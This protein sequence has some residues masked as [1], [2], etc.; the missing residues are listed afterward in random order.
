[1]SDS[2]LQKFGEWY[3]AAQASE[4]ND[5]NAMTVA[6]VGEDGRPAARILLLKGFDEDG[7][8]FYGN[9]GSRKGRAMAANPYVALLFHWKSLMRQVRIEGAVT[10]VDDATADAYFATRP[11]MSQI[12]A[13]ASEQS[14][15]L[16]SRELFEARIKAAEQTYEGQPVPRPAYWSGWRLKPDYFEFWQGIDFR[17]HDRLTFTRA[18][19]GW[20][21]GRLF[22]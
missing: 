16:A 15:P 9:L 10:Q 20:E 3:A 17:L 14:R 18:D 2:P 7:F 8:V 13:W 11:R 4:P 5:P 12:G 19:G 22:P 1:M 21:T 6:T